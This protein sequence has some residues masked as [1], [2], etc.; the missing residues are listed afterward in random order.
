[1]VIM[2]WIEGY[3]QPW[4]GKPSPVL[5]PLPEVMQRHVGAVLSQL[6]D[7]PEF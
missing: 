2:P 4:S 5:A 6:N 1:M 7:L 3:F